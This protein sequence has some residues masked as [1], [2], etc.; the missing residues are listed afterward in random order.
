MHNIPILILTYNRPDK[1]KKLFKS[2]SKIKPYKIYINCDG[3]KNYND[4]KNFDIIQV[5][6]DYFDFFYYEILPIINKRNIKVILITS[7]WHFSQINQNDKTDDV[8]LNKILNNICT[9]LD[10]FCFVFVM[11]I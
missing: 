6:V 4:I 7:Q 11:H 10:L 5:Q 2:L 1:L 8:M 3:P 9:K